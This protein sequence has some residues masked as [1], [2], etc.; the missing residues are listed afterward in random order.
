MRKIYTLQHIIMMVVCYNT[1]CI[2][3]NRTVNELVV[4]SI[5]RN[6]VELIKRG[7]ELGKGTIQNGFNHNFCKATVNQFLNNFNVLFKYLV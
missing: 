4:V 6:K 3:R 7:H 2:S 5:C 1:F